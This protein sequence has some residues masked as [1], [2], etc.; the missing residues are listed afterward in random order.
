MLAEDPTMEKYRAELLIKK[1]VLVKA[2]REM[3]KHRLGPR[4]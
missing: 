1:D 2:I 4:Y 3:E